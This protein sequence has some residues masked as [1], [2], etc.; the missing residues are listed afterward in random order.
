MSDL[1]MHLTEGFIWLASSTLSLGIGGVFFWSG[2][3]HAFR[4]S[5][6]V[7]FLGEHGILAPALGTAVAIV[8]P[9]IELVVGVGLVVSV[10][11]P[12]PRAM[13]TPLLGVTLTLLISFAV[14][15]AKAVRAGVSAPC[16]CGRS[17]E[18]MGLAT[19]VRQAVIGL[20]VG[21]CGALTFA[22]GERPFTVTVLDA[23]ITLTAVALGVWAALT[24]I[25]NWLVIDVSTHLLVN[26]HRSSPIRQTAGWQGVTI[27]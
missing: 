17:D 25:R 18:P 13:R 2:V 19:M 1:Q 27:P 24:A 22:V 7:R 10:A 11:S 8:L 3:S 21:V 15:T 5:R 23:V 9:V 26:E 14:Y 12:E 20:A 4:F 6:F 16:G